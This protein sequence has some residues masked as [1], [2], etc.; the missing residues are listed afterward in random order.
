MADLVDQMVE[1]LMATGVVVPDGWEDQARKHCDEMVDVASGD[2]F[3]T[4]PANFR[5]NGLGP[6][7]EAHF[8]WPAGDEAAS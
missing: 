8:D 1:V 7:T 3:V 6:V 2:V 5:I 4:P